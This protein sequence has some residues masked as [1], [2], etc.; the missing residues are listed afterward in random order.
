MPVGGVASLTSSEA[1]QGQASG[2]ELLLIR[3]NHGD[4]ISKM[5]RKYFVD[6]EF[7]EKLDCKL[8]KETELY[9]EREPRRSN[10]GFETG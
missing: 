3:K 4:C 6:R 5:K 8:H 2:E 1:S 9:T 10:T 7:K